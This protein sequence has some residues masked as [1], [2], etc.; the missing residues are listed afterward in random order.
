YSMFWV[1]DLKI[2]HFQAGWLGSLMSFAL[3]GGYWLWGRLLLAGSPVRLS[4]WHFRLAALFPFSFLVCA[5][6]LN[7]IPHGA[8]LAIMAAAQVLV[9]VVNAGWDIL[10]M[11]G[12]MNFTSRERVPVYTALTMTVAGV[13]GFG[14]PFLGA[15]LMTA[16]NK[17]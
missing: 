1:D 15:W 3:L 7:T 9:G 12:L 13:R 10:W 17:P 2:G 8:S 6:S 5:L 4:S 16:T 14:A 11:T